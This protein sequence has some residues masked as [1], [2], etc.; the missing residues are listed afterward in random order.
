[1]QLR[2]IMPHENVYNA[3]DAVI[4]HGFAA[5]EG[6]KSQAV[7][8]CERIIEALGPY[9]DVV[10]ITSYQN[11]RNRGYLYLVVDMDRFPLDDTSVLK[12]RVAELDR[13]DPG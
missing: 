4:A 8:F 1:M 2:A 5:V 7:P 11:V 10:P 3:V 12:R 13:L 9:D 6:T